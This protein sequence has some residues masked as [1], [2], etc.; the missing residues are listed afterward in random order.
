MAAFLCTWN[1]DRW[2]VSEKE[3]KRDVQKLKAGGSIEGPWAIGS[4]KS[5][6]HT[7]DFIFLVRVGRDR[8][9][10]ASGVA[11]SVAYRDL[12]WDSERATEN[13][14]ANYVRVDWDYQVEISNRLKVEDLLEQFPIVPWNNLAGSGVQVDEAVEDA[15]IEK[16]FDHL[17][18]EVTTFPDETSRY[19]EGASKAVMVNRYERNPAARKECLRI[20]GAKCAVCGFEGERA[21]G[22]AG[23]ALIHVH[24]VI[25]LSEVGEGYEVDPKT[26]L[27]PLC[28]NCHAMIHRRRPAYSIKELKS[29]LKK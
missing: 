10:V 24:H 8:G 16:W 9:I 27:V 4:R 22:S 25:E 20:F 13:K 17:G 14:L 19:F 15:L 29:L 23:K 21:Y 28:P 5:G 11:A 1:P 26:D 12:H 7:G 2:V 3:W 18:I 6:I